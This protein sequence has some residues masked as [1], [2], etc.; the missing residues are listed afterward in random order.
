MKKQIKPGIMA[1]NLKL[2][3]DSLILIRQLAIFG[4]S[5][6]GGSHSVRLDHG[7]RKNFKISKK[8]SKFF[9]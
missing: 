3:F 7:G 4:A 2:W 1:L 8:N 6:V 5:E 9:F